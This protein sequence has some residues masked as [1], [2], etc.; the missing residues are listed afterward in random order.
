MSLLETEITELRTLSKQVLRGEISLEQAAMQVAISNQVAKREQLIY[1]ITALN[2]KFGSKV[3]KQLDSKNLVSNDG[4]ICVSTDVEEVV[5][6]PAIGGKTVNRFECLDY[7]GT[8]NH[9]GTCQKCE[10]FSITRQQ[11]CP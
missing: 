10:H 4:A 7:S 8:E 9:I 11:T 1:N 2:A 6:C 5:V 3:M